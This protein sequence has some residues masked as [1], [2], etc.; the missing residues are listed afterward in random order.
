MVYLDL[1][2]SAWSADERDKININWERIMRGFVKVNEGL[3]ILAGGEDV[4]ELIDRINSTIN[5]AATTG[6]ELLVL[7]VAVEQKLAEI[8]TSIQNA[9]RAANDA[10]QM[11]QILTRL[12]SELE[13]L[14]TNLNAI[15]QAE[16]QRVTNENGRTDA[17][18]K[19][20][21]AEAGRVTGENNR[22]EAESG[23]ATAETA[24]VTAEQNR[25]TEF[26]AKMTTAEEKI[27]ALRYLLDN[28][29]SLDYDATAVFDFPNL[30]K[31]NGS[32]FIAL[33][34]VTGV[35]PTDDG[36][37]YRLVAQRGVDGT[38]AVSSVN[39][40]APNPDGN[41]QINFDVI[42]NVT[43]DATDQGLS[44]AMGKF[45]KSL[46]DTLA[47]EKVDAAFV[48]AE[49]N[50]LISAAPGMLDTFEEIA[51]ALNNDPNFA[52][53]IIN[54]LNDKASV[55]ALGQTNESLTQTNN[56]LSMLQREFATHKDQY[57]EHL[58]HINPHAENTLRVLYVGA[59]MEF[60]SIQS[61][62]NSIKKN[63]G[64]NRIYIDIADGVY[65]EDI[66]ITG[67]V[68]GEI[69]IQSLSR[70]SDLVSIEGVV[71]ASDNNC[72]N[73]NHISIKPPDANLVAI[74][75]HR[76]VFLGIDNLKIN[77]HVNKTGD[78]F[79]ITASR[80]YI[81]DT[82]ISNTK[83]ALHCLFSSSVVVS[84]ISGMNNDFGLS[85]HLGSSI[86]KLLPVEIEADVLESSG[87][88]G[89]IR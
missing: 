63:L 37:N 28:L 19:R 59:T 42:N 1:M 40:I 23:R 68:N 26:D 15:V 50:R 22:T 43:S 58:N 45:L 4:E 70:N 54:L 57:D 46:I 56:N 65:K 51:N 27:I 75:V 48:D 41:V 77:G 79:L 10:D 72:F 67:F 30:I 17:E 78:G 66:I 2:D 62:I 85:S 18:G 55:N 12:K 44:A 34:E 16:A 64:G 81:K 32:T 35:V 36:I 25:K 38:G 29:K 88:G 86:I 73:F 69:T 52:N 8:Q 61:A 74:T 33:Q 49:V 20:V 3:R 53:T 87:S 11:N 7:K 6:Q 47:I 5:N 14:Q 24:R 13:T 21:I 83:T 89:E 84:N 71:H 76:N 60:D 31:W 39:G 80:A 9:N 82:A